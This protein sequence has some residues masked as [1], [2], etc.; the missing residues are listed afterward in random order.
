MD[1][2]LLKNR[3]ITEHNPLKIGLL[4]TGIRLNRTHSTIIR[5]QKHITVR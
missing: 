2:T 4:L 3:V 5:K 1:N